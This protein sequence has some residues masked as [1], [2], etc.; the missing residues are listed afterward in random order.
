[1]PLVKIKHDGL[2]FD[3]SDTANDAYINIPKATF[4]DFPLGFKWV[5]YR[6]P[7]REICLWTSKRH[8][9]EIWIPFPVRYGT[10]H[11]HYVRYAISHPNVFETELSIMIL[12]HIYRGCRPQA[13]LD[14][15]HN[16][17]V[18]TM[19]VCSCSTGHRK[20]TPQVTERRLIISAR[21]HRKFFLSSR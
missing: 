2:K 11:I 12:L 7:G 6:C 13:N 10:S 3:L 8:G 9:L 4:C 17:T 21:N 15:G 18:V 20:H 5:I 1:M 14:V 19:R 16:S